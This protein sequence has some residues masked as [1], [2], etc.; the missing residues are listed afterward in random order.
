M[1]S[2]LLSLNSFTEIRKKPKGGSA[3]D[4]AVVKAAAWTWYQ[5][6]S[7]SEGKSV[8]E[9]DITKTRRAPRPSRYKLEAMRKAKEA[10]EGSPIHTN[11]VSLLHKY[12]EQ[13]ISRHLDNLIESSHNKVDNGC[14]AG[15]SGCSVNE[16][17]DNDGTRL[18]KNM[19]TMKKKKWWQR[20]VVICG[21]KED[22]VDGKA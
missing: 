7:G 5:H 19:M 2:K 14:L 4:L 10:K 13:S 21:T 9:F 20:H 6:G 17:S 16:S 11:K 1:A 15:N 22:V 3:E 12:E 18:K 8:T